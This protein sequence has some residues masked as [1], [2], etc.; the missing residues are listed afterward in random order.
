M[1]ETLA[2]FKSRN[3]LVYF[4]G[5]L[6]SVA[7][8]FMQNAVLSWFIY[9]LTGSNEAVSLVLA[10]LLAPTVLLMLPAGAIADRCDRRKILLATQAVAVL[11]SLC[12]W[13]L[14]M[15]GMLTVTNAAV[16]CA[17]AGVCLAFEIPARMALVCATV[18]GKHIPNA[19]ALNGLVFYGGL[20]IGR[21]IAALLLAYGYY[22]ACFL[23]NTV[24]FVLE[25]VSIMLLTG[26]FKNANPSTSQTAKDV[27]DGLRYVWKD[28]TSRRALIMV[29][30]F[31]FFGMQFQPLI[32]GLMAGHSDFTMAVVLAGVGLGQVLGSLVLAGKSNKELVKQY[33]W[34]AYAILAGA[35]YAL[36][37]T[38]GLVGTAVAAAFIGFAIP[39]C[40]SG[41]N[42]IVQSQATDQWRGR[43]AG[44][45]FTVFL[46]S[47]P[48]GYL[49]GGA[50]ADSMG[51]RTALAISALA[52]LIAAS[53]YGLSNA[54]QAKAGT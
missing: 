41:G 51:V 20:T 29:S 15:T 31:G 45:Y 43:V 50:L 8:T 40:V 13:G 39:L 49:T 23:V 6:P 5:Y 34:L 53:W 36:T 46:G 11:Q 27:L 33:L 7:G 9:K 16:L 19:M 32:N 47:E 52:C 37:L 18:D 26:S 12:V 28:S 38:S 22:H 21:A 17:I 24:S 4:L 1:K 42:M 54:K 25:L 2:T 44:V 10:F 30:V 48:I 14:A 35:I 3:F